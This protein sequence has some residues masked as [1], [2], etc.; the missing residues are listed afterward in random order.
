ML[1]CLKTFFHS[2][3]KFSD[4]VHHSCSAT[5]WSCSKLNISSLS[6]MKKTYFIGHHILFFTFLFWVHRECSVWRYG[7]CS[8][9]WNIKI[10]C[11]SPD[12]NHNAR[13]ESSLMQ[14]LATHDLCFITSVTK[15]VVNPLSVPFDGAFLFRFHAGQCIISSPES[16]P[17][18]RTNES[19][20]QM[21]TGVHLWG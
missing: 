19:P 18:I 2:L 8:Q 4:M 6:H 1:H 5:V 9:Y 14:L 3:K 7:T 13:N 17:A 12:W 11:H 16:K 20:I 21:V 10:L 15:I